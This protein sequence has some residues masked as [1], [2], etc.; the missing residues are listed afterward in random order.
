MTELEVELRNRRFHREVNERIV[1]LT[2]A[3]A[4]DPAC[5]PTMRVFCECGRDGC[6]TLLDMTLSEYLAVGAGPSRWV[7]S[8]GH[9]DSAADS[10]LARR[11]G[12][13]LVQNPSDRPSTEALA[14]GKESTSPST[15]E[16]YRR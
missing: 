15:A 11:D 4:R 5:D 10:T 1:E 14:P 8:S 16:S 7:V 9:I 2:R 12:F 3:F 13:A 6:M